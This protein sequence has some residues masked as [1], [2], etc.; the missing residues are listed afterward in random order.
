LLVGLVFGNGPIN[1]VEATTWSS[2]ERTATKVFAQ[3]FL[4]R[5]SHASSSKAISR[6]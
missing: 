4:T 1:D 2:C 3:G 5:L 6:A